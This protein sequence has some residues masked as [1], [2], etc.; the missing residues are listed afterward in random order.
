MRPYNADCAEYA[1]PGCGAVPPKPDRLCSALLQ[2]PRK[3]KLFVAESFDDRA[4]RCGAP[5][6]LEKESNAFLHLL[7]GVEHRLVVGIV[8]E[9][10]R[11]GTLQLAA[12][13]FVQD[14]ALQTS[15]EHMQFR[16]AHRSLKPQQ[17]TIIE[18]RRIIHAV[19]IE[20]QRV[21]ESADF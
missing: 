20:N 18:V 15:P 12:A 11:Q 9:A 6:C 19:F 14:P 7:V 10:D 4:G 8:D 17:E 1:A 3:Q 5:E 2:A 13:R 16:L 21:S